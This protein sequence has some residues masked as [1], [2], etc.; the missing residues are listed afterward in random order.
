MSLRGLSWNKNPFELIIRRN[1]SAFNVLR[2]FTLSLRRKICPKNKSEDFI[3][4]LKNNKHE[5]KIAEKIGSTL[6]KKLCKNVSLKK[7]MS[8][9]GSL[10]L[11][12]NPIIIGKNKENPTASK[13]AARELNAT[14]GTTRTPHFFS[15]ML[16]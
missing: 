2:S 8:E 11:N 16:L 13:T 5:I 3:E 4:M 6:S 7:L 9:R 12:K 1:A 15:K 14:N 10:T